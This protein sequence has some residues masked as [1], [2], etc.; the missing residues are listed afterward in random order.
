MF[1]FS[2]GRKVNYKIGVDLPIYCRHDYEYSAQPIKKFMHFVATQL[3][4]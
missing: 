2:S 4:L 3:H 1:S